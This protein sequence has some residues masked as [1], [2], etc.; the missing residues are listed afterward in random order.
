MFIISRRSETLFLSASI[1]PPFPTFLTRFLLYE[2]IRFTRE[3]CGSIL[4]AEFRRGGNRSVQTDA[5]DRDSSFRKIVRRFRKRITILITIIIIIHDAQ[6][7]EGE[8]ER[9]HP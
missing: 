7:G 8:E 1:R 2:K 9:A 4:R 6:V 5:V 3:G